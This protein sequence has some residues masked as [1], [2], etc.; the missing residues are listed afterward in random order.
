MKRKQKSVKK[1]SKTVN[2]VAIDNQGVKIPIDGSATVEIM[3]VL[4]KVGSLTEQVSDKNKNLDESS[5]IGQ[6]FLNSLTPGY[7]KME[8]F[9]HC[10][11]FGAATDIDLDHLMDQVLGIKN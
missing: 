7:S 11:S 10:N 6:Y 8:T 9:G 4:E 2:R 3:N 5:K 1:K